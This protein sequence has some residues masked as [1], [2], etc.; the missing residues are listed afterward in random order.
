MQTNVRVVSAL[1]LSLYSRPGSIRKE[2]KRLPRPT[3]HRGY[4]DRVRNGAPDI[5]QFSLDMRRARLL[6]WASSPDVPVVR[7]TRAELPGR[8][9]WE[10]SESRRT[11]NLGGSTLKL[12][13]AARRE[14]DGQQ[15]PR[16]VER[17]WFY[18]S[19]RTMGDSTCRIQVTVGSLT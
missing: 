12:R 14:R 2:N 9:T 13:G 4:R 11:T 1:A 10:A 15:P 8:R 3:A 19:V 16:V 18:M 6:Y 7:L 5:R 17:N